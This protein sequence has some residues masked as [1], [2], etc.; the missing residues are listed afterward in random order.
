MIEIQTYVGPV[1]VDY[2]GGFRH[3]AFLRHG[4]KLGIF[5]IAHLNCIFGDASCEQI[6]D[7]AT[8]NPEKSA[9][10]PEQI[11]FNLL[12]ATVHTDYYYFFKNLTWIF[13]QNRT[14]D[15]CISDALDRL[16]IN[17]MSD[18]TCNKTQL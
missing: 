6:Q 14:W 9:L 4:I 13:L 16:R 18:L 2:L 1:T 15:V 7:L 5:L 10:F 17:E 11:C 8:L 12:S 3:F